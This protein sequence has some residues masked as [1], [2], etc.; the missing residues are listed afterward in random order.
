V[1]RRT[2]SDGC[3][4]VYTRGWILQE[5][6]LSPRVVSFKPTQT[7]SRTL[8]FE[9]YESGP[10]VDPFKSKKLLRPGRWSTLIGEYCKMSLTKESDKLPA[11]SGLAHEYQKSWND[12]YL[13]GLWRNQLWR[14]LQWYVVPGERTSPRRPAEYRAPTWSW[15]SV[16]GL[17][18][19]FL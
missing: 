14:E 17:K 6:I 11:L 12:Q 1:P 5:E 9:R 2:F 18:S 16:E 13:A 7:Y 4:K 15:A 10:I 3:P 19:I 8:L